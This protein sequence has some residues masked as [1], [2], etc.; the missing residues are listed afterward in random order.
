MAERAGYRAMSLPN[1]DLLD[2]VYRPS[3]SLIVLDL[4]MPGVDG[5]E[6]LR[7]LADMQFAGGIILASGHRADLLRV[8]T[9][10]AELYG[11]TIVEALQKPLRAPRL[12]SILEGYEACEADT[13]LADTQPF[14][15]ESQVRAGIRRDQMVVH[16]QPKLA[17]ETLEVVGVEAL[18]RWQHPDSGLVYP[19]RF[20]PSIESGKVG[21]EL[22]E[23][24]FE[25]VLYWCQQRRKRGRPPLQ[26]SINLPPIALR[27]LKFPDRVAAHVDVSG[28][29][30]SRLTFEL[31][32]DA[33][34][35]N[36]ARELEILSRLRLKGFGLALDDFGTG[37][38][39]MEQLDDL[40]LT[41]LKIDKRFVMAYEDSQRARKIVDH[42]LRLAQDLGLEVIAEG[43][44]TE[45]IYEHLRAEGCQ[46]GQGYYFCRPK[47]AVD[48]EQW[49][50]DWSR[51]PGGPN[52][53]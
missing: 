48:F 8:A 5:L 11:L 20:I 10:V 47:S 44:E 29:E 28:I 7:K 27:D 30:R 16:Y 39:S 52:C 6:V 32:E 53:C 50:R 46:L 21:L 25:R 19:N 36:Q 38:A 4:Q 43:I 18:V 33:M 9:Q 15:L 31:V 26:V 42:S 37:Y 23:K 51:R 14:F 35:S 41:D 24:V 40:P 3:I 17:L 34:V 13:D 49:E 22:T 2:E 12:L 1:A 45:V